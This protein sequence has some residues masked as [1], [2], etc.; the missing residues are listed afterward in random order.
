[1]DTQISHILYFSGSH[2]DRE[3]YLPFQGFR[4][5]L[6][7]VLDEVLQVLQD[8]PTF[9]AY[10][11]DGQTV[12]LE[13]Y[14]QVRP[15]QQQALRALIAQ[16][17]ILV[18][19]WYT[20]PDE[21]LCSGESLVRNLL[22]GHALSRSLGAAQPLQCGFVCD[23]FGHV[24]Q[25]PQILRGFGIDTALLG[26]GTNQADCPA[27]FRWQAPD[28]SQVTVFK[29]PEECG[30]GTFWQDVFLPYL[31]NPGLNP[32]SM[33][34]LA[35]AYVQRERAR[36][37]LPYVVLMDNMDHTGIH[38]QAPAIAR[39]L[40][41]R[42]GCEVS[43]GH[44][45]Q[46]LQR[47]AQH[48]GLPVKQGELQQSGQALVVHHMLIANTLSSRYDLKAANG[49]CEQL[50]EKS[51]LPT[52]ALAA[53]RGWAYIPG[54][55]QLAYTYLLKNQAHDS[56]CGCSVDAVGQDMHYRFRQC[57]QLARHVYFKSAA[58]LLPPP[59][60]DAGGPDMAVTLYNPL[61]W[62]VQKVFAVSLP[63]GR[64]YP[65]RFD[66]MIPTQARNAFRLYDA[67][68]GQL[69][70]Q[71]LD[72]ALDS[73]SYPF[74]INYPRRQ[75]VYTVAVQLTLPAMG[76]AGF[77]VRPSPTPVRFMQSLR[78]GP[79]S[80]QNESLRLDIRAD[81]TIAL[82]TLGDGRVVDGLLEFSDSGDCG[83]GW[84][85]HAPD[86]PY[87]VFSRGAP[88]HVACVQDGPLQC[89][90]AIT[91]TLQVPQAMQEG[92]HNTLRSP[93]LAPLQVTS[94]VTLARGQAGVA[95]STTV[96][97]AHG[98]HRLKLLLPTGID[99]PAYLAGQAFC[100]V[101]RPVGRDEDTHDWKEA[102]KAEKAFAH[103][104]LKQRSDGSGL[105]FVSAGGLHEC[106][107]LPGPDG[108]L[109][110]TLLRAF[111]KTFLTD[112]EPDGQLA[113]QLEYNYLLLPFAP[114]TSLA[115]LVRARDE[116]T[117]QPYQTTA[118]GSVPTPAQD[119]G[120]SVEG[121]DVAVS[122]IKP[123]EQG[124]GLVLRLVNYSGQAAQA[125]VHSALPMAELWRCSLDEQL[126][127]NL[128]AQLVSGAS[129]FSCTLAPHAIQ[130]LV[131][132]FAPQP[133]GG[134][135]SR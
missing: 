31:Q 26:R 106:A 112:G 92:R 86:V 58:F 115:D 79:Y 17:R 22:H 70:W 82:T 83:D 19:P 84:H 37:P 10:V 23:V 55:L 4:F 16:G 52:A 49:R 107:A 7:K 1:M 44:I 122:L 97:N 94:R 78:T 27:F 29:V 98:S 88:A 132:V 12:L 96:L 39:D 33:Y 43:F 93:I 80:A 110:I 65:A 120:L 69:P 11:T 21:N 73:Y 47:A 36:S 13:D 117:L 34:Q 15:Q 20:M 102:D 111:G 121:K 133:A 100:F 48:P 5:R 116:L 14:L 63:F 24:A 66:G 56:I 125:A 9:A 57:V 6:V 38:P 28:A 90:F 2:W 99:S 81:G 64:D 54:Y 95:V 35:A 40:A 118:C 103:I 25:L 51:A 75:D 113:G 18:G 105:A 46:L 74:E 30:Y 8:D 59:G 131:M 134:E 53:C 41:Q 119:L 85:Y 114:S 87:T 60:A 126:Q 128:G 45:D 72:L 108:M 123:R 89:T 62:P 109:E 76:S 130:S 124:P 77:A 68:G 104:V 50:L 101:Q 32:D 3:W 129:Q 135:G 71:L 91:R 61:P 67:Q 127:E 42:F